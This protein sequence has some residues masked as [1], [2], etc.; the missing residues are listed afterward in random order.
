MSSL[1]RF[2]EVEAFIEGNQAL[3]EPQRHGWL[4][5][6]NYFSN[7]QSESNVPALVIIPTGCGKTGLMAITPFG[8]A[9]GRVL[10]VTPGVVVNEGVL[11]S[12]D[13]SSPDNFW[14]KYNVLFNGYDLPAVVRFRSDLPDGPLHMADMVVANIQQTMSRNRASLVNR[15]PPDF[16]DMI[17]VDEGHHAP[18]ESWRYLFRYFSEAK[19]VLVTGTPFRGDGVS[20][21]GNVA[22]EYTLGQAMRAGLVKRI[23]EQKH[24]DERLEFTV[25]GMDSR[26]SLDEVLEIKDQEWVN[27]SV[28]YSPECTRQVVI[29]SLRLLGEKR[30]TG[31]PH[32]ILASACSI[33]HAEQIRDIYEQEG[34]NATMV[35]STLDDETRASNVRDFEQDRYQV[36]VHVNMLGEG[37]DHP[38][39][40]IVAMFKPYRSLNQYVQLAGRA[41]R[42][43]RNTDHDD[44]DNV[45]HLVYHNELGLEKLW[46]YYRNETQ[47]ATTISELENEMSA[48]WNNEEPEFD[49]IECQPW[50]IGAVIPVG[51]GYAA[52]ESFLEDYDIIASYDR[53][54]EALQ[55]KL[56]SAI[57]ALNASGVLVTPELEEAI[58]ASM[59]KESLRSK[60][61]DLELSETRSAFVTKVENEVAELLTECALD[62]HAKDGFPRL[63]S[64]PRYSWMDNNRGQTPAN[65]AFL[66]ILIN[67]ELMKHVG[68]T[69]KEWT[70]KDYTSAEDR[71]CDI[72]ELLRAHA[73]GNIQ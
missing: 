34:S 57:E 42:V 68:R 8:V 41:L 38:S 39:I 36:I 19:K 54:K 3:L 73:R 18:A 26:F 7:D 51:L 50:E 64:K 20:I 58:L 32:K 29:E 30:R 52:R 5:I 67:Q 31:T 14:L 2:Q 17:I 56:E 59:R 45:A 70:L 11:E 71:L 65:N 28:A 24:I 1:C 49:S 15:V 27:R 10:V 46:E 61:P 4:R 66:V 63:R 40:S 13:S 55:S 37:Y 43:I 9:R 16:F 35:H 69:R 53:A 22:Y 60:R 72:L 23:I 48:V 6:R 25:D 44:I 47:R 33:A 62:P 21:Y 12:L